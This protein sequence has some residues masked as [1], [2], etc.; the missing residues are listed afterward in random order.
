MIDATAQAE[1]IRDGERG[2][3]VGVGPAASRLEQAV[4]WADRIP[5]QR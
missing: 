4:P 5:C 3:P 2:L 1:P